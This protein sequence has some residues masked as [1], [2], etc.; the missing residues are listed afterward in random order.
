MPNAFSAPT[1]T[2]KVDDV[3]PNAFSAPTFTSKVDVHAPPPPVIP[4]LKSTTFSPVLQEIHP[5]S[6]API[7]PVR[8][9]S[10]PMPSILSRIN[11]QEGHRNFDKQVP[12]S[13]KLPDSYRSRTPFPKGGP[14]RAA[15]DREVLVGVEDIIDANFFRDSNPLARRLKGRTSA[16]DARLML[17]GSATSDREIT[18]AMNFIGYGLKNAQNS[19]Q[20]MPKNRATGREVQ[21]FVSNQHLNSKYKVPLHFKALV[22]D[23]G[24]F[25]LFDGL[26]D[27]AI[28][29]IKEFAIE[30]GITHREAAKE[31]AINPVGFKSILDYQLREVLGRRSRKDIAKKAFNN[32]ILS[33]RN[34]LTGSPSRKL[35][36]G[37]DADVFYSRYVK[38]N[39][40]KNYFERTGKFGEA[41]EYKGSFD[42]DRFIEDAKRHSDELLEVVKKRGRL[43]PKIAELFESWGGIDVPPQ[44][45][46]DV[47]R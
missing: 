37:M 5:V 10:E 42:S 27:E 17:L 28:A 40:L 4:P 35:T 24:S 46:R 30:R 18:E 11:L 43:T 33:Q 2:S 16:E 38:S 23:I 32:L 9:I 7:N 44:L 36:Q 20:F 8:D 3:V 6:A 12:T 29:L 41:L 14:E 39:S 34:E 21:A 13:F 31:L 1:F 15:Y 26:N 25:S 22:D 19:F 47:L 45:I